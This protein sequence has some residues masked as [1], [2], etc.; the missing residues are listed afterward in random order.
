MVSI[1]MQRTL[2]VVDRLGTQSE[3]NCRTRESGL[4][5]ALQAP[6][7]HVPLCALFV[8]ELVGLWLLGPGNGQQVRRARNE[9]GSTK[10]GWLYLAFIRAST[11]REAC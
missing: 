2:R 11:R 6:T 3:L 4:R 9:L 8:G 5:A 7:T 1:A 10:H